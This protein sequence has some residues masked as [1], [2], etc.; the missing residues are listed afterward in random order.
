M[1]AA[2]VFD[3]FEVVGDFAQFGGGLRAGVEFGGIALRRAGGQLGFG[4]GHACGVEAAVAPFDV[5]AAAG[6]GADACA[7][8]GLQYPGGEEVVLA[9]ADPAGLGLAFVFGLV[10]AFLEVVVQIGEGDFLEFAFG[11]VEDGAGVA[12]HEVALSGGGFAVAHHAVGGGGFERFAAAVGHVEAH[13]DQVAALGEGVGFGDFEA[14]C[15]GGGE[16]DLGFAVFEGVLFFRAFEAEALRQAAAGFV[17]EVGLGDVHAVFVVFKQGEG[18]A[19][20]VGGVVF[21]QGE[22]AQVAAGFVDNG[23][24]GVGSDGNR[25]GGVQGGLHG[26]GRLRGL[27][28]R[29]VLRR[30]RRGEEP[31]PAEQYQRGD[32]EKQGRSFGIHRIS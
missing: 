10:A 31:S 12:G 14:G 6:G 18:F 4:G 24:H 19:F 5:D 29:G 11:G 16:A 9:D 27:L 20:V 1:D 25:H 32:D 2:V 28:L 7:V 3:Q 17:D 30:L 21:E 15:G 8:F 26:G 22:A 23:G 13:V